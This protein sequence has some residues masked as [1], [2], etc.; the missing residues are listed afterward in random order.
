VVSSLA[1]PNLLGNKRLVVVI[2]PNIM[3]HAGIAGLAVTYALNL[4]S[5]LISII[6]NI[7]STENKMVSVERILQYSGIPS[8]APLVL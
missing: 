1:Y 6:L 8:E 4:N 2:V 3:V 5:E 7:S